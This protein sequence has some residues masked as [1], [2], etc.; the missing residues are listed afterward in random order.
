MTGSCEQW[1]LAGDFSP[2]LNKSTKK[3][4]VLAPLGEWKSD[5]KLTSCP[6]VCSSFALPF[7]ANCASV[8]QRYKRLTMVPT[9]SLNPSEEEIKPGN[10]WRLFG[11]LRRHVH[12]CGCIKDFPSDNKRHPKKHYFSLIYA[13]YSKCHACH[14]GYMSL[15]QKKRAKWLVKS[16]KNAKDAC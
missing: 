9:G 15:S 11:R 13:L 8:S 12:R 16:E 2:L 10:I 7:G 4:L 6:S 5:T 1:T 3:W 14:R